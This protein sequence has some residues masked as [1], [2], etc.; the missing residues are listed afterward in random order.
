[1]AA[2]RVSGQQ[3][4][5]S[6]S[7][8]R[9][10]ADERGC[11]NQDFCLSRSHVPCVQFSP[12]NILPLR[13][14][15]WR[16]LGNTWLPWLPPLIGA[17]VGVVVRCLVSPIRVNAVSEHYFVLFTAQAGGRGGVAAR[18]YWHVAPQGTICTCTHTAFAHLPTAST[19]ATLRNSS[20]RKVRAK[21]DYW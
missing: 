19:Q 14:W 12:R 17:R 13:R 15:R 2:A 16:R 10:A 6:L 3:L 4:I 8:N 20:E 1:M 7:E 5:D 18:A 21:R 11:L 9:L